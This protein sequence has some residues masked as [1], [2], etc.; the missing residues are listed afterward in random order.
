M[1]VPLSLL[2]GCVLSNSFIVSDCANTIAPELT[3]SCTKPTEKDDLV[4]MVALGAKCYDKHEKLSAAVKHC[5]T[6]SKNVK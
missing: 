5:Q 2:N 4:D 1:A 6:Q 3:K